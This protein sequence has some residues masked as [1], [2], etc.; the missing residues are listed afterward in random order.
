V[1]AGSG[2]GGEDPLRSGY[3]RVRI[4]CEDRAGRMLLLKWRDP[5][6]GKVFYEPPGGGI[7]PGES[8]PE[9]ALRELREETGLGGPISSQFVA[10][11]RRCTWNGAY[12][13][14]LEPF[15][16]ACYDEPVVAPAALTASESATLIGWA[17]A[18]SVAELDAPLDPSNA[19]E[20]L[21]ELRRLE[22]GQERGATMQNV[23]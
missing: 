13:H 19:F 7:E 3:H 22:G 2:A 12:R 5:A 8:P 16:L 21:A 18:A 17:W 15:Y 23:V 6:D 14:E 9:A 20:V 4:L 10:V 11:E 1:T